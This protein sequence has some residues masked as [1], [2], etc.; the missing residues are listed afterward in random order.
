MHHHDEKTSVADT[1]RG[2]NKCVEACPYGVVTLVD[3]F[4][5]RQEAGFFARILGI[6]RQQRYTPAR[7][8]ADATRCVQCGICGYSCPQGIQVREWA[9]EGRTMDDPRCVSCGL[10][11]QNCPRGTLRFETYPVQPE[12]RFRADKCDLCKGYA[13]SACVTE[14]PTQAMLRVP[15]DERLRLLNEDLYIALTVVQTR[16]HEHGNNK[17]AD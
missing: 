7:I 12:P 3:R 6:A 13:N 10:C 16:Q 11:I 14:C 2:C 17:E 5:P 15:V 9:C 4:E 1:C 8:T